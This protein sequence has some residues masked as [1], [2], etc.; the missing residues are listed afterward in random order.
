[1]SLRRSI[2]ST[3][4]RVAASNA[5]ACRG[6]AVPLG[7]QSG[8]RPSASTARSGLC[9]RAD[10][11]RAADFG[12]AGRNPIFGVGTVLEVRGTGPRQKL[13]IRFERVGVKTVVL[14]YANLEFG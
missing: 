10:T 3:P 11:G 13:D 9:A 12:G 2:S 1:M 7:R 4:A 6:D 5:Y 14:R 8:S